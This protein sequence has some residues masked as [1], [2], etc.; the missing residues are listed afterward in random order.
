MNKG[1]L[2][3]LWARVKPTKKDLIGL[4][5]L[6]MVL[7]ALALW[8]MH[9]TPVKEPEIVFRDDGTALGRTTTVEVPDGWQ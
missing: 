4:F 8:A 3:A 6:W 1:R 7:Y 5:V 9:A 2:H